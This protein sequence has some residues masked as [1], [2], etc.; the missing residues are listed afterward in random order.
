[1]LL[2]IAVIIWLGLEDWKSL[3]KNSYQ[4]WDGTRNTHNSNIGKNK[5]V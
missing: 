1:M 2:F 5:N 3:V 4:D